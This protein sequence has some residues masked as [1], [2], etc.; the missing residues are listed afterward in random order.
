MAPLQHL[1]RRAQTTTYRWLSIVIV[2]ILGLAAIFSTAVVCIICWRKRAHRQRQRRFNAE[3]ERHS[4]VAREAGTTQTCSFAAQPYNAHEG[5]G[6]AS[7]IELQGEIFEDTKTTP[8]QLDGHVA[9]ATAMYNGQP[10]EMPV[11]VATR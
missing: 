1:A 10:V 9:P 7:P 4:L 6:R 2:V 8:Q 5:L 11:P 3:Q